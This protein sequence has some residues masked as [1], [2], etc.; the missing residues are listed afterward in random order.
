MR[1]H[2]EWGADAQLQLGKLVFRGGR[3]CGDIALNLTKFWT[4][5]GWKPS[6]TVGINLT[7]MNQSCELK[8]KFKR[9]IAY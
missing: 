7:G 1:L 6:V 5:M 4:G 9:T 3:I 8:G 2:W